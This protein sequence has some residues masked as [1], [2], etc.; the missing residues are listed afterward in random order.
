MSNLPNEDRVKGSREWLDTPPERAMSVEEWHRRLQETF[1]EGGVIGPRLLPVFASENAYGPIVDEK[2]A[3]HLCLRED[4]QSFLYESIRLGEAVRQRRGSA[5]PQWHGVL[6]L[7][8]ASLFRVFRAADVVFHAGYPLDGVS[9]LRDARDRGMYLAAVGR[10]ETSL[11]ELEGFERDPANRRPLDEDE[12]NSVRKRRERIER[13]VLKR[14]I[15]EESG[16]PELI[17]QEA[18]GW[19]QLFHLEVHGSRLSR[20]SE[21]RE[22]YRANAPLS[23][24]PTWRET[25]MAMFINR[26]TETAWLTH[27]CLPQLQLVS[28]EFGEQWADRW[29]VMDEALREDVASLWRMAKPISEA[30]TFVVEAKFEFTP[31]NCFADYSEGDAP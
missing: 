31:S 30:V 7:E 21:F 26:F 5:A 12:W 24:E 8:F 10:G 6:L 14:T 15:G 11:A 25:P 3:G 22:Y 16:L 18:R 27:R 29:R 4:F 20:A 9:L 19:T 2:S 23:L 1:H 13:A 28:R 17:V